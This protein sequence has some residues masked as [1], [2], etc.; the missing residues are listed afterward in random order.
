MSQFQKNGFYA[1]LSLNTL[2]SS[3]DE[4]S[5]KDTYDLFESP[6]ITIGKTW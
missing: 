3:H 6:I 2:M 5:F 1:D 4:P